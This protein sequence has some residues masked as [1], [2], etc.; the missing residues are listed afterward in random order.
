[1]TDLEI[2][3]KNV[4]RYRQL[5]NLTQEDLAKKV[6]VAK[7]TISLIELGNRKNPG[8]KKLISISQALDIKLFELFLENPDIVNIKFIV[9]KQNLGSMER[10][11]D[12]VSKRLDVRL[13]RDPAEPIFYHRENCECKKCRKKRGEK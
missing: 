1:M 10:L 12:E 4:K 3:A 8:L 13:K 5:K 11:L 2:L 9:S 6:A 7:D